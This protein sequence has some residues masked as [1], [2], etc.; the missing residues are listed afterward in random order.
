MNDSIGL[1]NMQEL[2]QYR[3]FG[4]MLALGEFTVDDLVK[5]SGVKESTVRSIVLRNKHLREP[6]LETPNVKPS[7]RGGRSRRFRINEDERRVLAEELETR[8]GVLHSALKSQPSS[9]ALSESDPLSEKTLAATL[10]W[11]KDLVNEAES[12][13]SDTD[14]AGLLNDARLTLETAQTIAGA[15][16]ARFPQDL[17]LDLTL[18][19]QQ[20]SSS[21]GDVAKPPKA[22]AATASASLDMAPPAMLEYIRQKVDQVRIVQGP[23]K[24]DDLRRDF[25]RGFELHFKRILRIEDVDCLRQQVQQDLK[26]EDQYPYVISSVER[27]FIVGTSPDTYGGDILISPSQSFNK[28]R[29][30]MKKLPRELVTA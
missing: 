17:Q 29:T 20:L 1:V 28:K 2:Q 9:P 16:T 30:L 6:I 24:R 8:Y 12:A 26:H 18:I 14:R 10:D 21:G 25:A 4:A 5:F 27:L 13:E 19:G 7:R 3:V 15:S 11:A 22:R 23:E